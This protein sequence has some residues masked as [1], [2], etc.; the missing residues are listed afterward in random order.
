MTHPSY[1][2]SLVLLRH[3]HSAKCCKCSWTACNLWNASWC[4]CINKS[5]P[6]PNHSKRKNPRRSDFVVPFCMAKALDPFAASCR[7]PCCRRMMPKALPPPPR[8]FASR[9]AAFGV[10]RRRKLC[11]LCGWKL[12]MTPFWECLLERGARKKGALKAC[13]N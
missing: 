2:W 1:L 13:F 7:Q 10:L 9:G 3:L 11:R 4:F 8:D 5:N 12:L 6:M